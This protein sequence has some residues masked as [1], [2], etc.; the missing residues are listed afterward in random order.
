MARSRNIKP[1]FFKNENLADL[2]PL[3]RLLFAGL[4]TLAD[5]DGRLE[6][7]PKRI[8]VEILPYDECSIE[9]L[10]AELEGGREQ[11]IFCYEVDGEQYIQINNFLK[12]QNPH[13]KEQESTIPAPGKHQAK[14]GQELGNNATREQSTQFSKKEE[15][16]NG[17]DSHMP[18][19]SPGQAP[20]L[21]SSCPAD[22]LNPITDSLNYDSFKP[23]PAATATLSAAI[24]IFSNNIHPITPIEAEKLEAYIDDGFDATVITYAINKAI[25]AGVRN[26]AYIDGI[27]KKLRTANIMTMEAVESAERDFEA[28]KHKKQNPQSAEPVKNPY[29]L[30]EKPD[31]ETM[32]KNREFMKGLMSNI[33][34][35]IGG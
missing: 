23:E 20:S 26:M 25:M 5:R 35:S 15:P 4:W 27:L 2:D 11:F 33:G 18:S 1:G 17:G 12:H 13:H 7:R 3:A 31:E 28:K 22:S 32:Q 8:K 10:L 29:P 14:L 9:E 34:K 16:C 24:K 30:P 21:P 19:T 6:N